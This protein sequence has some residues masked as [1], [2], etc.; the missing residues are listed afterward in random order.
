VFL[1]FLGSDWGNDELSGFNK[2]GP[3]RI[4]FKFTLADY[5]EG[6]AVWT[7]VPEPGSLTLV[8]GA[9][10]GL[11]VFRARRRFGICRR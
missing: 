7:M 10:V 1:E 9:A 11:G 4:A 8:L 3:T 2:Y 5:R 6:V